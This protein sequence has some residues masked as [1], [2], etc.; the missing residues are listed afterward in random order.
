M[1]P[2][3]ESAESQW[4]AQL[5]AMREAIAGLKLEQP[6]GS[7]QEYGHDLLVDDDDLTGDSGKDAIWDIFSEEE[8][9]VYSSD[10]LDEDDENL[11]GEGTFGD[12]HGL[13][14]LRSKCVAFTSRKSGLD[15]SELHEQLLAL[16]E[17]DMRGMLILMV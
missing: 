10:L 1:S 13:D 15:A 11:P 7:V 6:N 3:A 8:D 12:K 2:A 4:L 16:L 9:Y 14:W 5:A 17:S